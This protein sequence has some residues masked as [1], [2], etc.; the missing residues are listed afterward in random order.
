MHIYKTQS[1]FEYDRINMNLILF[2]VSFMYLPI[3]YFYIR[4]YTNTKKCLYSGHRT[5]AWFNN[6]SKR[7]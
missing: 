4:T 2:Y 3:Y 6:R 7:I 1:E 5:R